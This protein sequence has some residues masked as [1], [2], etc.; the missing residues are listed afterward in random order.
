MISLPKDFSRKGADLII[1]VNLCVLG[2][3]ETENRQDEL[4]PT[5]TLLRDYSHLQESGLLS[6][7][8]FLVDGERISGHRAIV[9][10]RC[11]PM[12]LLFQANMKDA[13]EGEVEIPEI[14]ADVFRAF[15]RFLYTGECNVDN[16]DA[17]ELLLLSHRYQ[18]NSLATLCANKLS[19]T[20]NISNVCERLSIA[21]LYEQ[22]ALES[23]CIDFINQHFS[24]IIKTDA[25]KTLKENNSEL[26]FSILES[27]FLPKRIKINNDENF[28]NNNNNNNNN[29]NENNK[30]RNCHISLS[31]MEINKM[32]MKEI[33]HELRRLGLSVEG[34]RSQ[35]ENRLLQYA[36]LA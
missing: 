31:V 25:Y 7:I 36:N 28:S 29:F 32:T 8:T 2:N 12:K 4:L 15:L 14:S 23:E 9:A 10:A 26:L 27:K 16:S 21:R 18:I 22:V 5:P 30:Q 20:L 33:K 19:M 13:N 6:D 17:A 24:H 34:F 35:L 1:E 3:I 11:E